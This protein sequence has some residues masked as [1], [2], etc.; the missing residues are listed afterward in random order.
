MSPCFQVVRMRS[1]VRKDLSEEREA[2][3]FWW[4]LNASDTGFVILADTRC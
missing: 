1:R 4:S 2:E 3:G